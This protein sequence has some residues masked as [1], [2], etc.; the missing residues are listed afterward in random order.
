MKLEFRLVTGLI[1][2]GFF[3]MGEFEEKAQ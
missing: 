1:F 2:L 3:Y